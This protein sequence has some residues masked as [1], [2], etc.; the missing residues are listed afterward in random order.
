MTKQGF[1]QNFWRITGVLFFLVTAIFSVSAQADGARLNELLAGYLAND[2]SFQKATITAQSA[3]LSLDATKISNGLSLSLSSG[4]IKI[5]PGSDGTTVTLEPQAELALPQVRDT[6]LSA[7]VPVTITSDDG[8]TVNNASV[9]V[10]TGIITGAAKQKKI[11]ILEAERK[12]QEARRSAQDAAVTAEKN[13]Y[14]ALKKLY[15]YAVSVLTKRSDLYDDELSLRKLQAQGYN[16]TSSTYLKADL[17]VRSDR[18]DV[19]EAERVLE[20]ETAVFAKKC[21]VDYAKAGDGQNQYDVALAFLPF[22][23][24]DVAI[25]DPTTFPADAYTATESAAWSKYIAQLKR[26]ADYKLTLKA[27]A[28]YTFNNVSAKSDTVDTGLSLTWN[29]FTAKAG[30]SFATGNTVFGNDFTTTGKAGDPVYTLSFGWVPNTW[31]LAKI[32][33]QQDKLDAQLED[34]AIQSAANDYETDMADKVTAISDLAWAKQSYQE[35]YAM[36]AQLAQD[37]ESWFTQGIVTESDLRD[38][39]DNQQ[40]AH[41]NLLINA[42]D[43]ILFNDETRLLFRTDKGLAE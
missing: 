35:E 25:L 13:F 27:N 31:R 19:T 28:G 36:Y 43:V 38:A 12:Y 33:A 7:D 37:T 18:R 8:T 9:S 32:D 22:T 29:G 1:G 41:I 2:L 42:I 23:V 5:A 6:T 34:I 15:N 10:A 21:G 40:K 26:E 30:V 17:K 20:R 14:T 4:T 16:R 24:P 39:R 11:T 3:S